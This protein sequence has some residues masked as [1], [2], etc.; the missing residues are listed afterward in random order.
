LKQRWRINAPGGFQNEGNEKAEGKREIEK[1]TEETLDAANGKLSVARKA[2]IN[3][4]N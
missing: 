4:K 1:R 2:A 3:V